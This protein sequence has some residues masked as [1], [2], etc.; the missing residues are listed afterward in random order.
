MERL[1]QKPN[2][3]DD[4]YSTIQE[5]SNDINNDSLQRKALMGSL[6]Y[7]KDKTHHHWFCDP[8][9][10]PMAAYTLILFSLPNNAKWTR[11]IIKT[12]IVDCNDCAIG[13]NRCKAELYYT[14]AVTKKVPIDRVRKV[15]YSITDWQIEFI[16]AEITDDNALKYMMLCLH[17]PDI[18]RRDFKLKSW[19]K[20]NISVDM[21][22]PGLIYFIFDDD[23][24]LREWAL[25]TI[26]S[27]SYRAGVVETSVSA[28]FAIHLYQ[29]QQQ[30]FY[31][32]KN[33][34]LFWKNCTVLLK[35]YE[36]RFLE[37]F[38]VP[39]D[40]DVISPFDNVR[41]FP[42]LK[43]F[44]NHL[45]AGVG[46]PLVNALHFLA[47]ALIQYQSTFWEIAEL[48]YVAYL[49][50]I[51]N[52]HNLKLYLTRVDNKELT[53][54]IVP[55]WQSVDVKQRITTAIKVSTYYLSLH[56]QTPLTVSL[57]PVFK[58][59]SKS[60][61]LGSNDDIVK[62]RDLRSVVDNYSL[63]IV[64][65]ADNGHCVDIMGTSFCFDLLILSTNTLSLSRMKPPTVSDSFPMLWTNI[66]KLDFTTQNLCNLFSKFQ[67]ACSV[68]WFIN[69]TFNSQEKSLKECFITHNNQVETWS[70]C[71]NAVLDRISMLD[72]TKLGQIFEVKL[73]LV[74]FW[75]CLFS[76]SLSQAS[77]DIIYQAFDTQG[78]FEGLTN[79]L[80]HSLGYSIKG[81]V[82]GLQNLIQLEAYEPL[83]KTVRLLMDITRILDDSIGL[84]NI[85][86]QPS[87]IPLLV[88][89]W[90][91]CWKF[92]IM[93][94]RKTLQWAS[95]YYSNEL[96]EFTRDTLD[97]SHLL[98]DAYGTFVDA[99][100]A[101]H[102][103]SL[104]QQVMN[105]FSS[106][107]VW[108]RLSD[109]SLLKSCI[110]LVFKGLD[111][112]QSV[113]TPIDKELLVTLVK[114]SLK[115]KKFNSKLTEQQRTSIFSKVRDVDEMVV[116]QVLEEIT[117]RESSPAA[118]TSATSNVATSSVTTSSG[119]V[120]PKIT[121]FTTKAPVVNPVVKKEKLSQMQ[122][123][124]SM[125]TQTR[126]VVAP[127]RAPGFNS[128]LK[129]TKPKEVNKLTL[130]DAR[131]RMQNMYKE[132]DNDI[133]TELFIK[134]R[135]K[136]IQV[137]INGNPLKKAT[138]PAVDPKLL[139]QAR[140]EQR[141]N[142]DL[143]GLYHSVL[144]WNYSNNDF[145]D[146]VFKPETT[147]ETYTNVNDYITVVEPLLLLETWSQVQATKQR[148]QEKVFEL[149]IGRRTLTDGFFDLNC[150]IKKSVLGDVKLTD[151][152][153]V[154]LS[155]TARD[156][157]D[158]LANN[159]IT[160]LAKVREIKSVNAEVADINLRISSN[161]PML[162]KLTH[163]SVIR[164]MKIMPMITVEREY[165]SLKGLQYYDLCDNIISGTSATP[166][167]IPQA[168]LQR[169]MAT[170]N[171]NA[172][173]ATAILG[174]QTAKGFSLIQGP[175]GTGKTKTI[176]GIVGHNLP[177]ERDKSVLA[178][179]DAKVPEKILI[180]APSNAAVDELVLRI[181]NGI[182][183]GAGAT[184]R[185]KVVRLGRSDAVNAAVK[186]CTLEELVDRQLATVLPETAT[187]ATTRAEHSKLTAQR[188]ELLAQKKD[189]NSGKEL[190]ALDQKIRDISKQRHLVSQKL[191][192][193]REQATVAYRTREIERRN[194]QAKILGD[195][196]IIC[197]TLSGSAHDFLAS[198][199]V[200]FNKVIID[201]ACQCV[202][203]SAIIP[204]RY[205][206]QQCI[207]VGDPNQLPPTVISQ[208]AAAFH[209]DQSL[210]VRL[211]QNNPASVYLL[212]V[213]YRMHPEI[214]RFP[215]LKFYRGKLHNGANTLAENQRSWH[216]VKALTPY[217]FFNVAGSHQQHQMSKSLFNTKEAQIALELVQEIISLLPT[218]EF[219]GKIGIISPYKE[220]IRTLKQ[221]FTNK[222][223]SLILSEI[224][225]NTVDGFQGQE[226]DIIIM[227]CVRANENGGVGFLSDVRRMNVALTRAKST[228]W[229]LGN[230]ASL[231]ANKTWK[232]LIDDAK[233]RDL[234]IDVVPGFLK[235]QKR[236]LDVNKAKQQQQEEEDHTESK[237]L[238]LALHTEQKDLNEK[239][240]AEHKEPSP[241][242]PNKSAILPNKPAILPNKPAI[243]PNKPMPNTNL[244]TKR[245]L[246]PKTPKSSIFIHRKHK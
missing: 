172:S 38:N 112:A 30:Q 29:I 154:V 155:F 137:D 71:F 153:L 41:Y 215:S 170:F 60:F 97:L 78:R 195:A 26:S 3:Y 54:W 246:L 182:S 209:Y 181:K 218:T 7:L 188:N 191:D 87:D 210:F 207:M 167:T 52:N 156:S 27:L 134:A 126:K 211:Q 146:S 123:A 148:Q 119:S 226:K 166:M 116:N 61:I 233:S 216:L 9:L 8:F 77:L 85:T 89:L 232:D 69:K 238:K 105:G 184:V 51:F 45:I 242:L 208:T 158:F 22:Y 165:S 36:S 114:Y 110:E 4:L 239:L 76:G 53:D 16:Q 214:S 70:K 48:G 231:L 5:A 43:V 206:C 136:A 200:K 117:S 150:S 177:E 212:D 223:G 133:D 39:N 80:Q 160:T 169:T 14:F 86:P 162:N 194:A 196:H 236:S 13:F 245:N 235:A 92:M 10:L 23:L 90:N 241:I 121:S 101:S 1:S 65:N 73:S 186:D 192:H 202:E 6:A 143:R 56:D 124:R 193:Q 213:Q 159:G 74:G 40:I 99:V 234:L 84:A 229:V 111:L 175:P 135:K 68:V 127:P 91:V 204:L 34:I 201:E 81:I 174:T 230:A 28:E 49:D 83:P 62:F 149:F 72:S 66:I 179:S 44:N 187:D 244:G 67:N 176:L 131:K 103:K 96:V 144:N 108:L 59:L 189:A 125:I 12:C 228:L 180:C 100:G 113:G 98:L 219:A 198:L 147:K 142:V 11:D 221:V 164:A 197:A 217:R 129:D 141:L 32:D 163:G 173:Q 57:A 152:D 109:L 75:S 115:T 95:V 42:L 203:L 102:S 140:M 21:V 183:N 130:E 64:Q 227:S 33:A 17:D 128:K 37:L 104:C 24:N 106:I 138:A 82:H 157:V 88:E 205:G 63:C 118:T 20:R 243:L 145:D 79:L 151:T 168:K 93:L 31:S 199:Y 237:K 55:F 94:Y 107:L 225:F 224:D 2:G 120:Q 222:Y 15:T 220:Q 240:S 47:R 46:P 171:V 161:G 190:E 178:T 58:I 132:D 185:P 50:I 139:E 19:F 25:K 122:L 18:L 35:H